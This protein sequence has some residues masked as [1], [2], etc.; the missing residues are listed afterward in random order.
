MHPSYLFRHLI[1]LAVRVPW[2]MVGKS[3]H[4]A[5]L[6]LLLYLFVINL[7]VRT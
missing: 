1:Q 4:C 5:H 3:V 2:G 6:N 7:F